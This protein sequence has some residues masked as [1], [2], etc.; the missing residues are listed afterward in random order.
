MFSDLSSD[1]VAF[2]INVKSL[3]TLCHSSR[4]LGSF[5]Y[6]S[7]F[8][9]FVFLELHCNGEDKKK[10]LLISETHQRLKKL[11]MQDMLLLTCAVSP[12]LA[13]YTASWFDRITIL[14]LTDVKIW[15][16]RKKLFLEG[17]LIFY[18]NSNLKIQ[19]WRKRKKYR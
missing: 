17:N 4:L 10:A 18:K 2:L 11:N 7:A 8:L 12:S 15:Y 13:V 16:S 9:W 14:L 5:C 6:N 3:W 19:L 1:I